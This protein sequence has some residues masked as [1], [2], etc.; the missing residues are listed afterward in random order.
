M[1][2]FYVFIAI[3]V[4]V[5]VVRSQNSKTKDAKAQS[6]KIEQSLIDN[7]MTITN[8]FKLPVSTIKNNLFFDTYTRAFYI[9]EDNH[10]IVIVEKDSQTEL[11]FEDILE[12]EIIENNSVQKSS[13]VGR[14]IVGGALAGGVGA[15]IGSNTGKSYDTVTSLV[16]KIITQSIQN[17]MIKI[18]LINS[19]VKRIDAFYQLCKEYADQ[20]HAV[21][22][23]IIKNNSK[24]Q[25]YV[26]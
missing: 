15:I 21:L 25:N 26:L 8:S 9:D 10:K 5:I 17:P 13:G 4:C 11:S 3:V 20:V 1:F 2:L 22:T 23:I 6:E 12:C 7:G 24:E 16:I 14:A 18:E 19:E